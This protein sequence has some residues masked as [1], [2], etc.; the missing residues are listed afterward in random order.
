MWKKSYLLSKL[1]LLYGDV[2][3]K[4]YLKSEVFLDKKS[5]KGVCTRRKN[6]R[7]CKIVALVREVIPEMLYK[8][9]HFVLFLD[10]QLKKE[11][12]QVEKTLH[13]G[14]IIG[15]IQGGFIEILFKI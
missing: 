2:L 15:L 7:F 10:K 5:I 12:Y 14:K 13:L 1:L 4:F 6:V 3:L 9:P 8:F 11:R